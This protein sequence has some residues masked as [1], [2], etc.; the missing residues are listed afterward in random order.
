MPIK[1]C[2]WNY[3]WWWWPISCILQNFFVL[4]LS[5]LVLFLDWRCTT[6]SQQQRH[7]VVES[8]SILPRLSSSIAPQLHN[9]KLKKHEQSAISTYVS[10]LQQTRD[11]VEHREKDEKFKQRN[12]NWVVL[13]D[14]EESIR[15]AVG[16]YLY[17]KGYQV[18]ACAD[19]DSLLDVLLEEESAA[20]EEEEEEEKA[21]EIGGDKPRKNQKNKRLP[22]AIIC[23]IRMPESSRNGY[24]LVEEIRSNPDLDQ[25][26]VIF[27]TAKAMTQDRIQGYQVGADAFLPKP[28]DA[29]ELLS[30]LDNLIVRSQQRIYGKSETSSPSSQPEQSPASVDEL[31]ALKQQLEEIKDIMKQNA[32]NTVQKTDVYLTDNEREIL[33]MICDGYTNTEI[34]SNLDVKMGT[35]NK[36][37][38]K[39]YKE[40]ETQTRTELVK[41]AVRVGYVTLSSD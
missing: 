28:F 20:V 21:D 23:D 13:V 24:Q 1:F 26:P 30:I 29:D 41:W 4:W 37:V 33:Q 40:T 5:W 2:K 14:D 10:H 12:E 31:R 18:T 3:Y 36:L 22:D 19:A 8:F 16:E 7:H 25:I 6:D 27:L 34:A 9:T 15:L 17:D 38:Q 35:I 32:A 39:L 11:A